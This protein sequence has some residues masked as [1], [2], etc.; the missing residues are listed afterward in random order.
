MLAVI[1]SPPLV[2]LFTVAEPLVAVIPTSPVA[3]SI[4][5]S[6][7]ESADS[8]TVAPEGKLAV[9]EPRTAMMEKPAGAV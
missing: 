6:I 9:P 4:E 8:T 2:G 5:I 1:V 3:G 7:A